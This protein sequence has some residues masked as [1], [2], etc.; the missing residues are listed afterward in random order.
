M[1]FP[2]GGMSMEVAVGSPSESIVVELPDG[3]VE[4]SL[5]PEPA[6][7]PGHNE[8][9]AEF[10]PDQVLNNI[11]NDLATLYEADKDS[12][13]EWE[14][15]YIKGLDLLGLK[16]EDRTQPWEGACG[17]FHPMLSEAIVRFQAQTIQEIFPA[18]G[19]V[20][21]KI[22]GEA[23]RS[24]SKSSGIPEL[25]SDGKDERIS[26]RDGED[27][28]LVGT[29]RCSVPQGLLRSFTR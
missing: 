29:L 18:K 4:I 23:H 13:K 26:L 20:Q 14:T 27:A 19:P 17:V 24:G 7:E 28:L 11:G 9:L 22:L 15:T 25:S 3:G 2:T 6:P 12:R 21:T 5:S 16:I 10:I 8:N 1:P